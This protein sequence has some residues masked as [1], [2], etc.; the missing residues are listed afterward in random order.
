MTIG[1]DFQHFYFSLEL[2][3]NQILS[4]IF[5]FF[6]FVSNVFHEKFPRYDFLLFVYPGLVNNGG[7]LA[8]EAVPVQLLSLVQMVIPCL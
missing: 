7:V 3:D 6:S 8:V 4:D 1:T 2:F 5:L